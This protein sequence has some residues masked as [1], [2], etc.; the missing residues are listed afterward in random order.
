M[1]AG[2]AIASSA[3]SENRADGDRMPG[4]PRSARSRLIIASVAS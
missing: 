1:V 2:T 3:S 4:Y